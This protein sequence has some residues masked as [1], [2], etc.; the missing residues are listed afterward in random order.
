V[1]IIILL[2]LLCVASVFT[3]CAQGDFRSG[4]IIKNNNDSIT[5]LVRYRKASSS[6]DFCFFK[7]TKGSPEQKLAPDDLK[8]YGYIDDRRYE[9]KTLKLKGG[10]KKVF[11]EVLVKG[12]ASLYLNEITFYFE[13]D[14]LVEL[15][16]NKRIVVEGEDWNYTRESKKYVG[17]LNL[18]IADCN[19]NA[20][21][22][23]YSQRDLTNLVQKYNQCKGSKGVAYKKN[24]PWA[25]LYPQLFAG[26]SASNLKVDSYASDVFKTSNTIIEG[27]SVD[28]SSPRIN[29]KF[30]FS[31][32]AWYVKNL[33]QGYAESQQS[34]SQIR[35][36]LVID[37]SYLKIPLG[38]RF[39]LRKDDQ[40]P[41]IKFGVVKYYELKS[42]LK[43]IIERESNAVVTTSL[44]QQTLD[45]RNLRGFWLAV[46]YT[47]SLSGRLKIFSELRYENTVGSIYSPLI[48]S[49]MSNTNLNVLLGL[50]F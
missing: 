33:Y 31:I 50:R 11:A 18:Q 39:N 38:L 34:T 47:K 29:S 22:V 4:F 5:G 15:P 16:I 43:I 35:E 14:S 44:A 45:S 42:S 23:N 2:V 7:E 49:K 9:T 46:G 13:K 25:K 27:G 24:L 12:K 40:T 30:F 8:A 1:K 10:G 32:E 17:I 20:N 26:F 21:K 19:L 28:F 37:V 41:Y 36:D 3:V 48:D 6:Y